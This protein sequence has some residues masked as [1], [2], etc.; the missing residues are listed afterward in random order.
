MEL[1]IYAGAALASNLPIRLLVVAQGTGG[2]TDQLY[3]QRLLTLLGLMINVWCNQHEIPPGEATFMLGSTVVR[4]DDTVH[5][6]GGAPDDKGEVVVHAVPRDSEEAQR[7]EQAR[8]AAAARAD[9][10]KAVSSTSTKEAPATYDV[11]QKKEARNGTSFA[12]G[13]P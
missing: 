12:R 11:E 9:A 5:S 6:L 10:T 3:K 7:A 8:D 1:A 13:A 2:T 4:P